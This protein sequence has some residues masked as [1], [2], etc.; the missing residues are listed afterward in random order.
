M[1]QPTASWVQKANNTKKHENRCIRM[2]LKMQILK[3]QG[4]QRLSELA[5]P[6]LLQ[7]DAVPPTYL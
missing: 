3:Y 4:K 6:P 7:Y 5:A 2:L 1:S